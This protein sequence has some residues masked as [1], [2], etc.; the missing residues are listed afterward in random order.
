MDDADRR[1]LRALQANP[2][3]TMRELGEITG[4]SHT[5][6]WRRLKK[7]RDEGVV[8][9]KRYVIDAQAAGYE[10]VTFCFVRMK[11]HGRD[12]LA[13]FEAAVKKVPEV[14]QCHIIAG[15]YDYLLKVLAKSVRH[16]EETMKHAIVDLPNVALVNTCLAL[17]E[18]KNTTDIPI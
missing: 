10:I 14:V 18:V 8:Q 7:L 1:I 13:E 6:C 12:K 16:Y 2:D 5:P 17:N 9:E 11:Q 3:L 15:E 4:L